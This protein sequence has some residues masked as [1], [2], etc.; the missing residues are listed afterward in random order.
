MQIS[1]IRF[2]VLIYTP[3]DG[4]GATKLLVGAARNYVTVNI[5]IGVKCN[6]TEQLLQAKIYSNFAKI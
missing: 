5:K 1:C 2:I 3:R 6:N 4:L